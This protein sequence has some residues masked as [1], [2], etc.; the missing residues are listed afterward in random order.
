MIVERKTKRGKIFYG[1]NNY[2][3]CKYALWDKPTGNIC[4]KCGSLMV[5]KNSLEV[6]SEC[7]DE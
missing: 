5:T 3:K 2:P 4:S 1:C 6:C 7:E